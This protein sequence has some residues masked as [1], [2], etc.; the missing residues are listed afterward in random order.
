MAINPAINFLSVLIPTPV[1]QRLFGGSLLRLT[2]RL[3]PRANH[4]FAQAA[5]A[6]VDSKFLIVRLAA[7][8]AQLTVQMAAADGDPANTPASAF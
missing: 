2:T 7:L 4:R 5:D 8:P 1:F 3:E 6:A